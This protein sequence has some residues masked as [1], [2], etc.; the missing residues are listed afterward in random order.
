MWDKDTWYGPTNK[1]C[2]C[3]P[4]E[5]QYGKKHDIRCRAWL[6]EWRRRS[7]TR[8]EFVQANKR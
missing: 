1:V 3:V 8:V 6:P 4:T 7:S 5:D 2:T